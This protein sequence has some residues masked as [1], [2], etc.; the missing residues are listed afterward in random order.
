M[1]LIVQFTPG[2]AS[3]A[4]SYVEQVS[5]MLQMVYSEVGDVAEEEIAA[6]IEDNTMGGG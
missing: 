2:F 3:P 6:A 4:I 1:A 5:S